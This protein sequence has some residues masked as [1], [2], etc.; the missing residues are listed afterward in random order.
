V[1][2]LSFSHVTVT[3]DFF[4][5]VVTGEPDDLSRGGH[6]F[7]TR[8]EGKTEFPED[9]TP[10]DILKSMNLLLLKPEFIYF[11]GQYVFLRRSI[12]GVLVEMKL[13][14]RKK[15]PIPEHFFPIEGP[16]VVRN[17]AG[18]QISLTISTNLHWE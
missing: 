18:R 6:L 3:D 10:D 7:G 12:R 15:V 4:R 5:H 11:S 14:M 13:V 16:G 9:W 2:F 17:V 1:T 8:R